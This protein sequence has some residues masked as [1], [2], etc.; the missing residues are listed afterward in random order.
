MKKSPFPQTSRHV[1][2]FD[3]DWAYL[4]KAYGPS[5]ESK[6]GTGPAIRSIVHDTVKALK[7]REEAILERKLREREQQKR[8]VV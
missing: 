3:E 2:I 4:D 6:V 8:A 1:P 7:A 5:S